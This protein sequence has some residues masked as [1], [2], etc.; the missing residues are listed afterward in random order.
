MPSDTDTVVDGCRCES[1]GWCRVCHGTGVVVRVV[2]IVEQK[3]PEVV[4]TK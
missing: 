4:E 2:K 3:K 1:Q